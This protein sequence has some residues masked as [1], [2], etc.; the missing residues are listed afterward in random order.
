[1]DFLIIGNGFDIAHGLKTQYPDFLSFCNDY[2]E[3]GPIS[4]VATLNAEFSAFLKHNV[5][6]RYFLK[7]SWPLRHMGTNKTWIDFEKEVSDII[8]VIEESPPEVKSTYSSENPHKFS[9][10]FQRKPII[11]KFDRFLHCFG[12]CDRDSHVYILETDDIT[13]LE[14]F[15]NFLYVQLREFT[16]AFEIY[17]LKINQ[18]TISKP[19]AFSDRGMLIKKAETERLRSWERL[20]VAEKHNDDNALELKRLYGE[21]DDRYCLLVSD[22]HPIDYLSMGKF[23]FVL[24]FN[25]TNTYERLYGDEKTKYCYIHGKAQENKEHTNLILGIDD[26]LS[27]GAESSNFRCIRFKKYYQRIIFK[28]GAEYKDWLALGPKQLCPGSR[29]H[30]VGHSLDRTDHD[31]L[32]EFFSDNRFKIIVYY[33]SP[34]DFEEK[35]QGVIRLLAYKGKNGRD[36][37]ISRVHGRNWSIKFTYLYDEKEGLFRN[38]VPAKDDGAL[39]SP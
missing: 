23:S 30:I 19:I 7:L 33:Y 12:K 18:T 29:V 14:S 3:N 8:Q 38:S 5:W 6:L 35:I 16:R 9:L 22:V 31:V 39:L 1:M 20:Q 21:A 4:N 26:N 24:S 34:K 11:G 13:N 36:E 27:D 37:L 10:D 17:C 28:T 32:Y 2:D 15:L 25:Y